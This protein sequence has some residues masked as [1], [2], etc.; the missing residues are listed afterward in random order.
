M[1]C[2]SNRKKY[3]LIYWKITFFNQ[4]KLKNYPG[5]ILYNRNKI[6]KQSMQIT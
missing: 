6:L 5:S 3:G 1:F 2:V 4:S